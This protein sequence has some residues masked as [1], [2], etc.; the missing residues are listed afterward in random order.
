MVCQKLKYIQVALITVD[1][2]DFKVSDFSLK[3]AFI[4]S[5]ACIN[6]TYHIIKVENNF[7]KHLIKKVVHDKI[8]F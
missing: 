6:S 7:I 2:Y 4:P 8:L 5:L 3:K 1:I